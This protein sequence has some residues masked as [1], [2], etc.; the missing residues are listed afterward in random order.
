MLEKIKIATR[1]SPLALWQ[2]R[3][4]QKLLT[5]YYPELKVELVPLSTRGDEIL[6]KSLSKIG[7][8]GLFTKNLEQAM[9]QGVADI[10]VHSMKDV[11]AQL[12]AG[13][14]ISTLLERASPFDA[15]VSNQYDAIA[16]LPAGAVVGTSSLRRK[17]QLLRYRPDLQ[18]KP[19]RGNVGTRLQKLEDGALDAIILAVAG[20]E[21]LELHHRIRQ[22][23]SAHICLPAVAQGAV[24]IEHLSDRSELALLLAPLHHRETAVRIA[25]ERACNQRLMGGCETP[26]AIF[27]VLEGEQLQLY[28]RVGSEDGTQMLE[29]SV[30]GDAA[31]SEQ[32]GVAVAED[33]LAQGAQQF[34]A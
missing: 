29:A 15:F 19:L 3:W 8:K 20:L 23:L 14:T 32:I 1:K 27:S 22:V 28:A 24:G 11:P 13:F 2:A 18:C 5:S 26:I 4:V 16:N 12:P 31:H 10:A 25:C 7:G 6:D 33:L 34:L 30:T 9:E 17:S 21:R